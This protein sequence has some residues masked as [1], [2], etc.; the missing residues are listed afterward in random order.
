MYLGLRLSR[1]APKQI[2]KRL[3]FGSVLHQ[4]PFSRSSLDAVGYLKGL[5]HEPKIADAVV[6]ALAQSGISGSQALQ[7]VKTLA[8]RPEVGEDAGLDDLIASVRQELAQS[9]GKTLVKFQVLLPWVDESMDDERQALGRVDV[10]A[11]EGMSLADVVKHSDDPGAQIMAEHMEC[12]CSGIMACSTCHVMISEDWFDKV[13]PPDEDEQDM[14][15]L[16]FDA[17]PTSRLGCQ[18]VLKPELSGLV[19]RIPR[20]VNNMM[21][22]IYFQD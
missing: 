5:G 2:S 22:N 13:G 4:R 8:G 15:E 10:E 18:V 9:E 16:A 12:A 14:L 21:D 7:M 19:V 3:A 20:G 1:R 17:R 6:K 11:Y